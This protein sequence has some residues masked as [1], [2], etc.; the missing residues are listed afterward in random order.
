MTK[1]LSCQKIV[2]ERRTGVSEHPAPSDYLLGLL[3]Q[4]AVHQLVRLMAT[5]GEPITFQKIT[6]CGVPNALHLLRSLAA[7]GF[8]RRLGTWDMAPNLEA[9]FELTEPGW[10]LSGHLDRLDQWARARA[11]RANTRSWP[12]LSW[13]LPLPRR[14]HRPAE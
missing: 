10:E 12:F 8:V 13:P 7:A 9:H 1:P 6:M 5:S 3:S 14:N 11:P 4:K 2:V